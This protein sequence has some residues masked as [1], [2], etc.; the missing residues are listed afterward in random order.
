[1]PIRLLIY[2]LKNVKRIKQPSEIQ[3]MY[4]WFWKKEIL[5][6][7]EAQPP[8]IKISSK[9]QNQLQ[10]INKNNLSLGLICLTSSSF[11]PSL[12]PILPSLLFKNI[13]II[14]SYYF[15]IIN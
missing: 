11:F 1:M 9:N 12:L 13:I 5:R 6:L 7:Q 10:K 14:I 15:Q 4:I 2:K 8:P 3:I